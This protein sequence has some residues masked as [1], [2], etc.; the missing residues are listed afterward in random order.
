M[1]KMIKLRKQD[2]AVYYNSN[3]Q[4]PIAPG[5]YGYIEVLKRKRSRRWGLCFRATP[6]LR[7]QLGEVNKYRRLLMQ[8]GAYENELDGTWFISNG[9]LRRN[10]E[11]LIRL[12]ELA[13]S[14]HRWR[15]PR[16]LLLVLWIGTAAIFIAA[17]AV[18]L[19]AC[20]MGGGSIY[21]GSAYK[22]SSTGRIWLGPRGFRFP[23]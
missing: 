6:Q 12:L 3:N 21:S 2:Q 20:A 22:I 18:L 1:T 14:D 13:E 19:G 5:R 17:F 15:I 7:T 23:L 11:T 16:R 8:S 4:P 9:D 10:P